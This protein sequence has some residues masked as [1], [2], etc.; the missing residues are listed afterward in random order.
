MGAL[1]IAMAYLDTSVLGSYYCLETL[2]AAIKHALTSVSD[3]VI[4]ALSEVEFT[5]LLSLKVRI[6]DLDH[7]AAD[8]TRRLFRKHKSQQ[9]FRV[10]DLTDREL[11]TATS[12]LA[13]FNTSLRALD[14]LHLAIASSDRQP[15]WTTDKPLATTARAL[16]IPC[17]LTP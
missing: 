9:L 11:V 10:A 6:G 13:R 16:G 3:P 5:S 2:S 14:A 4:S 17:Q 12:W 15:I 1:L 7:A 8:Q